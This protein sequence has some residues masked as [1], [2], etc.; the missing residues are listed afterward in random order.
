MYRLANGQEKKVTT[1]DFSSNTYL[2]VTKKKLFG[3]DLKKPHEEQ[4]EIIQL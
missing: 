1:F 3:Q 4:S 2:F